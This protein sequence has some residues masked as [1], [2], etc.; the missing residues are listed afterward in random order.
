M[1]TRKEQGIWLVPRATLRPCSLYAASTNVMHLGMWIRGPSCCSAGNSVRMPTHIC[2]PYCRKVDAFKTD[3]HGGQGSFT[4]NAGQ[5]VSLPIIV[6]ALVCPQRWSNKLGEKCVESFWQ[7]SF[8]KEWEFGLALTQYAIPRAIIIFC[9]L[10][11][12]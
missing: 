11:F 6:L 4:V 1:R 10:L 2:S 12:Q 5:G 3:R 8:W 9:G 7:S